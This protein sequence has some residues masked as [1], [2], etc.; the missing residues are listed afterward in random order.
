MNKEVFLSTPFSILYLYIFYF[1]F[2]NTIENMEKWWKTFIY[3]IS[4]IIFHFNLTSSFTFLCYSFFYI[5]MLLFFL[6]RE[7]FSFSVS[8]QRR[9]V[10]P[11]FLFLCIF[12]HLHKIQHGKNIFSYE[13]VGFFILFLLLYF[14]NPRKLTPTTRWKIFHFFYSS[15]THHIQKNPTPPHNSAFYL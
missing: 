9:E 2:F 12:H 3:H 11:F 4:Y 7:F 15:L 5:F 1:L 8:L 10:F 6:L 14:S 13:K